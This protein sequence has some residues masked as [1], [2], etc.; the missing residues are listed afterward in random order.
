MIIAGKDLHLAWLARTSFNGYLY[1]PDFNISFPSRCVNNRFSVYLFRHCDN[2]NLIPTK[3]Q[4]TYYNL[5]HKHSF[6]Y[7]F[8]HNDAHMFL[9]TCYDGRATFSEC[10]LLQLE[11]YV[12]YSNLN[13]NYFN[14]QDMDTNGNR[15]Y[16]LNV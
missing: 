9:D 1:A 6:F 14:L 11:Y 16:P 4:K 10:K 3:S 8:W 7:F 15:Q 12:L 5:N 13:H 2:F